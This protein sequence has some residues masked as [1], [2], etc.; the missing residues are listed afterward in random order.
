MDIAYKQV[1]A[2]SVYRQS[3]T[4]AQTVLQAMEVQVQVESVEIHIC[5][6]IR[7]IGFAQSLCQWG[8]GEQGSGGERAS[9]I[10]NVRFFT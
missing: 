6:G 4:K 5:W 2:G 9:A 8:R 7:S 3:L 10:S 1:Q